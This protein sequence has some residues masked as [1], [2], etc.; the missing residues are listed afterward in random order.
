MQSYDQPFIN[1]VY[2]SALNCS[3]YMYKYVY[4]KIDLYFS[5]LFLSSEPCMAQ[6]IWRYIDLSI[7]V[8]S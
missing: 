6:S 4:N 5:N 8:D 7:D 1:P 3:F 2:K